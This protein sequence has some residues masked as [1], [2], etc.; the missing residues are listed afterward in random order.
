MIL[1]HVPAD[2]SFEGV[3]PAGISSTTRSGPE[4]DARTA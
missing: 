3:F 1:E 4:S 2:T